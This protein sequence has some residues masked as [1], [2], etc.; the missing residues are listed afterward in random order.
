MKYMKVILQA[1]GN[2]M[3]NILAKMRSSKCFEILVSL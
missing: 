3:S 2:D 1:E